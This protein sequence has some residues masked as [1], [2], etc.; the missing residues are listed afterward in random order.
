MAARN[1]K[2]RKN[3]RRT[4]AL[5]R[6]RTHLTKAQQNLARAEAQ[7]KTAPKN[8]DEAVS[9]QGSVDYFMSKI[10]GINKTITNTEAKLV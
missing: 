7:L 3:A 2:A 10:Q 1:S 9:A 5:A 6:T 8:S 4:S